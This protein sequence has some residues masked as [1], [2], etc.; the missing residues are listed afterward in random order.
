ML[1]MWVT[2]NKTSPFVTWGL[3]SG[4]YVYQVLG[5]TKTYDLGG[6]NGFIHTATITGLKEDTTYYYK[7][8][9]PLVSWS[10]EFS[11]KTLQSKP[12]PTT[13]LVYGDMG[14]V[15][16]GWMVTN[17]ILRDLNN[18]KYDAVVHL[19]DISYASDGKVIEIQQLWDLFG[20]QVEPISSSL[21]YMTVVGNHEAYSNFTAYT[22]RF[23]MP[24]P[25]SDGH[26]NHW[27]SIDIGYA[28]FTMIS[29]EHP[30]QPGSPQYRWIEYDLK[31]ATANRK[32]VPWIFVAAHKPI[33][34]S[35]RA[36]Y[37][38]H[39]PGSPIQKQ[40]E[41]LLHKYNVDIMFAGHE[42]CYERTYPTLNG[43]AQAMDDLNVYKNP[44]HPFWVV[45][46]NAGALVTSDW[47][48]PAPE[49]SLKTYSGYGFGRLN[50]YNQTTL[51]YEV[52]E[53]STDEVVDHFWVIKDE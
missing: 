27:W 25:H 29:S 1:V 35:V 36:R 41:P 16:F 38:S 8:G 5:S 50:I 28:H 49:W 2:F 52:I 44:K 40:L 22:N 45:Q 14:T 20:I 48:S 46:G 32:N 10:K 24:S 42:H 19:G 21:P 37:D 23:T 9:D 13:L 3:K 15:P 31:K 6:W 33:Y 11:F 12:H 51:F 47:V 39:R 17:S 53:A 4:E 18:T 34:S 30:Y 7:V 26:L 43:N